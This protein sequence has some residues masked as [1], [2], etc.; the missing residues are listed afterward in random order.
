MGEMG[1]LQG[2]SWEQ[3]LLC[4]GKGCIESTGHWATRCVYLPSSQQDP[5]SWEGGP[6]GSLWGLLAEDPSVPHQANSNTPAS[7]ALTPTN[8]SLHLSQGD[9]EA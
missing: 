6:F 4:V 8:P 1:R 2:G 3:N 9:T 5:F 7:R